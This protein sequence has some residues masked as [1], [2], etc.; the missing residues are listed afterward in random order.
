MLPVSTRMLSC[1]E[2]ERKMLGQG[3]WTHS[4]VALSCHPP[5]PAPAAWSSFGCVQGEAPRC[6]TGQTGPTVE[7]PGPQTQ[8]GVLRQPSPAASTLCLLLCYLQD[9]SVSV[10]SEPR[11]WRVYV[12][13]PVSAIRCPSSLPWVLAQPVPQACA[14]SVVWGH[15]HRQAAWLVPS[16]S[17]TS[18]SRS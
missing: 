15:V 2:R 8:G 9:W 16:G 5:L 6:R 18:C 12:S 4:S 14:V 17:E 3:D 7:V 10:S 11:H 13:I 1:R